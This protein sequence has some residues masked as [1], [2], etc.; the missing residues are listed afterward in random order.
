MTRARR[1]RR[2]CA[3]IAG[4]LTLAVTLHSASA[5][6]VA[7]VRLEDRIS[8]NGREL[9]LNGAGVRTRAIFK[10]Y[11]A[12]L[13]LPTKTTDAAAALAASA[14]RIELHLLRTLSSDQL[15]EAL[16]DGLKQNLSETELGAIRPQATQLS[17]IMQS[18][19][20]VKEGDV[21]ALDYADGITRILQGTEVKGTIPGEAF[22]RALGRIWLGERAVQADL[23]KALLGG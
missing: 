14:R 3:G 8:A 13:Y 21:V 4:V 19:K 23:K 2:A 6:E 15:V 17:E 11:A 9:V 12:G 7:G 18:L 5:M 10:V 22:S 16:N 1:L 20:Q